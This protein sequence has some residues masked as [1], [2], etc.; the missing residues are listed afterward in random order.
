[1]AVQVPEHAA[2]RC[3]AHLHTRWRDGRL[4]LRQGAD[5]LCNAPGGRVRR[6]ADTPR[7]G[8]GAT[9]CLG[10]STYGKT[11]SAHD[12]QQQATHTLLMT[13]TLLPLIRDELP[14][15]GEMEQFL[16]A[17]L[18]E[19][20]GVVVELYFAHALRQSTLTVRSTGFDVHQD[21]EDFPFIEFTVV[22]KLT[23]DAPGS[24]HSRMRLVGAPRVFEY[25][26][27]A[28]SAGAFLAR[29][30]HASI[31]PD[32]GTS[33]HL[34]IAFFF[35]ASTKGERRAK[36]GLSAAALASGV[37]DELARRRRHVALELSNSNLEAQALAAE[38]KLAPWG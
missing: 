29:A 21:T 33:E 22:V 34:K 26:A 13:N 35:R 11:L 31:E 7:V 24:P 8:V 30:F 32:A 12:A 15:F 5:P 37:E 10:Y 19:T 17:W 23:P 27:P 1:M 14:G 18:H 2:A 25:G 36:R 3:A 9:S 6:L 28:G 20:Y 4:L 16:V 38:K